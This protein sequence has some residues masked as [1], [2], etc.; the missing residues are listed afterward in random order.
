MMKKILILFFFIQNIQAQ[1]DLFTLEDS[2]NGAQSVQSDPLQNLYFLY[3]NKLVR[4]S[5]DEN[6]KDSF[7][8]GN[9]GNLHFLDTRF[10]HK[11]LLFFKNSNRF[12]IINNRMGVI[13]NTRL[14]ALG[15]YQAEWVQYAAD[16]LIW[17]YDSDNK[18]LMKIN[19][20]NEVKYKNTNISKAFPNQFNP[21]QF[22]DFKKYLCLVDYNY[23]ILILDHFGNLKSLK[24][25]KLLKNT[26]NINNQL[27][28]LKEDGLFIVNIDTMT[29]EKMDIINQVNFEKKSDLIEWNQKLYFFSNNIFEELISPK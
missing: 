15:I 16:G 7:E 20:N 28:I 10:P 2:Y 25:I 1:G 21:S 29:L 11:K 6:R 4:Y 9:F 19:E 3:P 12:V 17:C 27:V 22:I 14:D 24:E 8:Y 18:I 13:S 5:Q 26:Y 23:G